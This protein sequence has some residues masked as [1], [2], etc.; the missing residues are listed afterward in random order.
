[1]F[2]QLLVSRRIKMPDNMASKTFTY[3]NNKIII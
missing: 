2:L 3:G 1:M